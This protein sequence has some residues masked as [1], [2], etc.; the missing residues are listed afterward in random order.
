MA[1]LVLIGGDDEKTVS[2]KD[3]TAASSDPAATNGLAASLAPAAVAPDAA[4]PDPTNFLTWTHKNWD[5]VP[6]DHIYFPSD[7]TPLKTKACYAV[8]VIFLNI[9]TLRMMHPI[10]WKELTTGWEATFG[11]QP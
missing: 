8:A 5:K 7:Q 3:E 11:E 4:A 1:A 10:V 2:S 6:F 9:V